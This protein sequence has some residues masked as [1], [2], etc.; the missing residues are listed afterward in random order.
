MQKLN[1]RKVVK[2]IPLFFDTV[3]VLVNPPP[4]GLRSL[5]RYLVI[6]KPQLLR[7]DVGSYL[8]VHQRDWLRGAVAAKCNIYHILRAITK[9]HNVDYVDPASR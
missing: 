8:P 2:L 1:F 5:L 6:Y 3:P 7:A 9:G 4:L